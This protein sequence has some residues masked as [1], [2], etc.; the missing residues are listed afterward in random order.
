MAGIIPRDKFIQW[1][2]IDT[3][4]AKYRSFLNFFSQIQTANR[5]ELISQIA[6]SLMSA[7]DAA[8]F[9]KTGFEL[10]GHTG[11]SYV[12]IEDR[13]VFNDF[14]DLEKTEEGMRYVAELLVDIGIEHA[15]KLSLEDYFTGIQVGLETHRRKNVGGDA[16]KVFV[17]GK[18]DA[19]VGQ[20][21]TE[22]HTL[23]LEEEKV[24]AYADG[25]QNKRVDFHLSTPER[26]L[27]IEVNF[28]TSSGSKP[29]EIKRSYGQVN[30]ALEAVNVSLAWVTDGEGY[31]QM[32]KSLEDAWTIHKNIY[33]SHMLTECFLEDIKSYFGFDERA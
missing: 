7:D 6:D 3:K 16:F 10:L 33:N 31:N 20:L 8:V 5:E 26:A 15:I 25:A 18:L 17:R 29:T 30:Q 14:F 2:E 24:I 19:M 11:K 21:R 1:G 9:I 23:N 32:V 4:V 22:G 13:L 12:S 27:G 28:Y